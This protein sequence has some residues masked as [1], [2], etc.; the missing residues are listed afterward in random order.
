MY[1]DCG[2]DKCWA[3]A[4]TVT[5]RWSTESP[6][7]RRGSC[8]GRGDA[9]PACDYCDDLVYAGLSDWTLP[10]SGV[11][12]GLLGDANICSYRDRACFGFD[13]DDVVYWSATDAEAN[14]AT[15]RGMQSSS[16]VDRFKNTLIKVRCVRG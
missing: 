16:V 9:F 14:V 12:Y 10:I 8:V 5:Y 11:L 6:G 2:T 4:T 7:V 3:P 15:A 13:G 1:M